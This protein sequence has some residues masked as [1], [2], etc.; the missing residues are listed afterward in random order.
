MVSLVDSREEGVALRESTRVGVGEGPTITP[1]EPEVLF[2]VRSPSSAGD[3]AE[4]RDDH[5]ILT[6]E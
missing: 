2:Q 1:S 6:A 3:V 4:R 5:G